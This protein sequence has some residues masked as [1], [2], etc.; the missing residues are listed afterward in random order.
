LSTFSAAATKIVLCRCTCVLFRIFSFYL[1]FL[2]ALRMKFWRICECARWQATISNS[3][4]C[5]ATKL[6][7]LH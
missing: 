3:S 6:S 2:C 7:A 1:R 5:D 4:L